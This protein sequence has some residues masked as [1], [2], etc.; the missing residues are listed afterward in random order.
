MTADTLALDDPDPID[1]HALVIYTGTK[2]LQTIAWE[3]IHRNHRQ[4][5]EFIICCVESNS[6]LS[7]LVSSVSTVEEWWRAP[8]Q[9][10]NPILYGIVSSTYFGSLEELLPE[11][12][13]RIFQLP[14]T[15]G[16]VKAIVCTRAA[17]EILQVTPNN[18]GRSH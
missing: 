6:I 16:C 8:S 2:V 5:G 7:P 3:E 10:S 15:E 18:F 4:P 9:K 1:H 12:G 11:E 13:K 17:I 14:V